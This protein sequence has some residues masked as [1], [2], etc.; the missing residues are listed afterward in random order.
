[1]NRLLRVYNTCLRLPLGKTVFSRLVCS[2]APYFSS[3]KPL[4][5]ELRPGFCEIT[6]KKRRA[7]QNHLKSVHAIA[8][9]NICELTAGTLL[10]VTLP[11]EYRWIPQKMSVEYLK[12]AK[13]DLKARSR[14]DSVNWEGT[15]EFPMTVD[16]TDTN[17]VVVMRATIFMH[18]SRKKAD[19]V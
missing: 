19:T 10:E 16:V 14:I 8:M 6:M 18:I 2:Q 4:F 13:T 12:I 1:M 7:V 11:R 17:G 15:A 9:C 5:Q 3:I